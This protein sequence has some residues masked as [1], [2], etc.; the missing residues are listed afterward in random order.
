MQWKGALGTCKPFGDSRKFKPQ[1]ANSTNAKSPKPLGATTTVAMTTTIPNELQPSDGVYGSVIPTIDTTNEPPV[2]PHLLPPYITNSTLHEISS[3]LISLGVVNVVR[4]KNGTG[5]NALTKVVLV[6]VEDVPSESDQSLSTESTPAGIGRSLVGT[7]PFAP[8]MAPEK[9]PYLVTSSKES[10]PP[11]DIN[12]VKGELD[13][14][15][16]DVETRKRRIDLIQ[17]Y[18]EKKKTT[19]KKRVRV[20][21]GREVVGDAVE[22]RDFFVKEILGGER[23]AGRIKTASL[24]NNNSA[25][26][27]VGGGKKGRPKKEAA[28]DS[29]CEVEIDPVYRATLEILNSFSTTTKNASQKPRN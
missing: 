14:V 29:G 15:R 7:V 10:L 19:R 22:V 3:T 27:E 23:A 28:T 18:L 20:D 11:W 4:T 25:G 9:L 5:G 13:S 26:G 24:S 12:S 2:P 1:N 8:P 6:D 17:N 21:G 16:A